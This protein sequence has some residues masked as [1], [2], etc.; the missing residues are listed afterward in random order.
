M[1]IFQSNKEITLFV[2]SLLQNNNMKPFYTKSLVHE[3]FLKGTRYSKHAVSSSKL[4]KQ[5]P[6]EMHVLRYPRQVLQEHSSHES[7]HVTQVEAFAVKKSVA[8]LNLM[9]VLRR[10]CSKL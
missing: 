1:I 2:T 5:R 9:M 7:R 8:S 3:N 6:H 10:Y 4:Q